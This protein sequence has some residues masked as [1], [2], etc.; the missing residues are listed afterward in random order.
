M[1]IE[2][3][4]KPNA[5]EMRSSEEKQLY[6][7]VWADKLEDNQQLPVGGSL[8]SDKLTHKLELDFHNFDPEL[9]NFTDENIQLHWEKDRENVTNWLQSINA[10]IDPLTF[11]K[12]YQVKAKTEA[13]LKVDP[14][15]TEEDPDRAKTL[16]SGG[17]KLSDLV[18]KSACAER[19]ALG[20]YLL[21]KI[22]V[23]TSYVS[24]ATMNSPDGEGMVNHAFIV[25]PESDSTFIF[26]IARPKTF[27]SQMPRIMATEKPYDY[28]LINGKDNLFVP[29]N[30]VLDGKTLYFGVGDSN[31][32]E[33]PVILQ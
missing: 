16:Y 15:V 21:Q 28:N 32:D 3:G 27:N 10:K 25:V 20:Q 11:Y 22:G 17:A 12:M 19:A 23:E 1:N 33:E 29:A 4:Y 9:Q 14:S 13:L 7:G 2:S 5:I 31:I 30:D 26:D 18:G 6:R 24:G 8:F